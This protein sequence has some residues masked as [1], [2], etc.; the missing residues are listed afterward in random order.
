[1]NQNNTLAADGRTN[2]D[3][4]LLDGEETVLIAYPTWRWRSSNVRGL[5]FFDVIWLGF[6]TFFTSVVL[7]DGELFPI[8]FMIP[9]W[10]VGLGIPFGV[11]LNRKRM[12]RTTY[13]L[14]N[15]RAIVL[16]PNLFMSRAH[17]LSWP[18][19]PATVKGTKEY[20][21][22]SGD[23]VMGFKDYQVN[24]QPVPDGF[25]SVPEVH[26]VLS[27][28]HEQIKAHCGTTPLP[29]ADSIPSNAPAFAAPSPA[30]PAK[31]QTRKRIPRW[32]A[33][34]FL[35]QAII[36]G[37]VGFM[38]VQEEAEL[39]ARG[40]KTTATVVRIDQSDE[41]PMPLLRFTDTEGKNAV[42]GLIYSPNQCMDEATE[43]VAAEISE[44]K[45][46]LGNYIGTEVGYWPESVA[47][48]LDTKVKEIEATYSATMTEAE[49]QQQLEELEEAWLAF[50]SSLTADKM[51]Q[52][53]EGKYYRMSTP[54]RDN[55]FPTGKGAGQAIIGEQNPATNASVWTFVQR[56]NGSF[57]IVNYGD[58]TYI[59]PAS[60]NNT[61]LTTVKV[62]PNAGWTL[63]P[64]DAAGYVIITSGT[65]QF[66]QTNGGQQFKLYNWGDGTN[67]TDTGC[68]Y[69]VT[70]VEVKE[71]SGDGTSPEPFAF[72]RYRIPWLPLCRKSFCSVKGVCKGEYHYRH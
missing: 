68:K 45:R 57:D 69:V 22:G 53:E 10:L 30:Q 63:K 39:D 19:S 51:N 61:A 64:A 26:R 3:D 16:R 17:T 25:I 13:V 34:C 24:D 4:Y 1:M 12:N 20:E 42:D 70:E 65:V 36:L 60:S 7:E 11:L 46:A 5:L 41:A 28:I 72:G 59:S 66:N 44:K 37:L 31:Q 38:T 23:I 67:I 43:V 40:V 55:R 58:Q 18:L 62:Q 32:A 35:P 71:D 56:E 54:L 15:Q 47:A 14:T 9:F 50:K 48:E 2:I 21:D 6:I 33:I 49:R 29:V 52:P 8:L 27:A